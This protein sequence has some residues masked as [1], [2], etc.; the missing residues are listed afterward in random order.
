M[1][2]P[3]QI[4]PLEKYADEIIN[5]Y[6]NEKMSAYTIAKK[7]NAGSTS[8]YRFL[9]R[10]KIERRD[11]SHA[12]QIHSINESIFE[13]I[14]THE[15]AYWLGLLYA[16][17][18]HNVK[19]HAISLSLH[20]EDGYIIEAFKKFMGYGG[21]VQHVDHSKYNKIYNKKAQMQHKLS[22]GNKKISND[23]L[24]LGM[25]SNKT[26]YCEFPEFL[27]EQFYS[28]FLLGYFDGD[29]SIHK[30]HNGFGISIV[31]TTA[32][33][34]EL[35]NK[36]FINILGLNKTNLKHVKSDNADISVMKYEGNHQLIKIRDWM[37]QDYVNKNIPICMLR[38][39]EIFF[40]VQKIKT[41]RWKK[42]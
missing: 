38:K 6:V 5:L 35:Q 15:K 14:D 11:A 22:I 32:F 13:K 27:E 12:K 42:W 29:G 4:S 18:T 23:L 3:Q 17:G 1:L 40:N 31:G 41:T 7:Y 25:M 16:D 34:K 10:H 30:S 19:H 21:I 33:I 2:L 8:I 37:Y 36:I 24:N 39:K 20:Y 26:K 9:V 28:S